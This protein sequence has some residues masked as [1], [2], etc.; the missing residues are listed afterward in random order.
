MAGGVLVLS[1]TLLLLWSPFA[2]SRPLWQSSL[3]SRLQ[4]RLA[5]SRLVTVLD[6]IP[7]VLTAA[8]FADLLLAHAT[9]DAAIPHVV[10]W[11]AA[12]VVPF[13]GAAI[14]PDGALLLLLLTTLLTSFILHLRTAVAAEHA[15]S[16]SLRHGA[17]IALIVGLG[18]DDSSF[19]AASPT[20]LA[21]YTWPAGLT[22]LTVIAGVWLARVL[23]RA[24]HDAV[25]PP[26][27]PGASVEPAKPILGRLGLALLLIAGFSLQLAPEA[28]SADSPAEAWR[29]ARMTP[30]AGRF[31]VT[32]GLLHLA[33]SAPLARWLADRSAAR[34]GPSA[35][36]WRGLAAAFAAHALLPVLVV[37][38]VSLI[39]H[40][41]LASDLW[42]ALVW[43]PWLLLGAVAGTNLP[44]LGLDRHIRPELRG[45]GIG[46]A[47]AAI[48][49]VVRHPEALL[50]AR[51]S[52]FTVPLAPLIAAFAE[53]SR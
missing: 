7:V 16:L 33:V 15:A 49:L 37:A 32:L 51:V 35:G 19:R 20:P 29:I 36:R 40:T 13:A 26:T 3:M 17:L 24:A 53:R 4:D 30:A 18:I 9:A 38:P 10:R 41:T 31:V 52:L 23:T 39:M 50:F 47:L 44:L 42:N 5:P 34:G 46:V 12:G 22:L 28:W 6:A 45:A 43:A 8:A 14:G 1:L 25:A 2:A 27:D 21:D 48:L 11:N